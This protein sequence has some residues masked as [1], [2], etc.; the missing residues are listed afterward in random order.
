MKSNDRLIIGLLDHPQIYVYTRTIGKEKV[1]IL[2]N[3]T[4]EPANINEDLPFAVTSS[5]L[6]LA[7]I[8][9]NE[10]DTVKKLYLKPFEARVYT[11]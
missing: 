8:E 7:N 5:Q 4:D 9:V 3:L 10:H 6:L 2:V 1:V 11:V